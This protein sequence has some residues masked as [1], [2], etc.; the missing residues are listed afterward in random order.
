QW[1]DLAVWCRVLV[2]G[3]T[4][5]AELPRTGWAELPPSPYLQLAPDV[6]DAEH[7]QPPAV[8]HPQTE[9]LAERRS[10]R[11]AP[12]QTA[13]E[14]PQPRDLLRADTR[15]WWDAVRPWRTGQRGQR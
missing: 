13:P 7:G 15:A 5:T 1:R 2:D 6:L 11:P 8:S 10:R 12:V 4:P 14:G 3:W 9:R